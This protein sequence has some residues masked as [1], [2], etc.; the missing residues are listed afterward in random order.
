[1]YF[2]HKILKNIKFA[3]IT[4]FTNWQRTYI[5]DIDY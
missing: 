2:S 4:F 5:E 3:K 1:L